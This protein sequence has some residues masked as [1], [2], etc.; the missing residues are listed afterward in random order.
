[1]E[2]E[3]KLLLL[4]R[5][6]IE[7]ALNWGDSSTWTNDD[8]EQL[9]EKIFD[10]TRIQLSV[11]TLKRIWGKVRYENFP[12]AGTLNALSRFLDYDSWRDFRQ[13]NQE[14]E[15]KQLNKTEP[16]AL[17]NKIGSPEKTPSK[18]RPWRLKIIG[19][20]FLS[21][22]TLVVIVVF[23]MAEHHNIKS[24]DPVTVKFEAIKASDDLPNSV[25]LIMMSP[26]LNLTVCLFNNHGIHHA[27]KGLMVTANSIPPSIM[28]PAFLLQS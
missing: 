27:G 24:I 9:S 6:L 14:D 15:I 3:K 18:P 1:M 23:R 21:L 7:Q 4:C 10:K 20:A 12:T 2:Q 19:V 11:S 25:I 16:I 17:E 13:K 8:F 26:A 28:S 22:F 5:C